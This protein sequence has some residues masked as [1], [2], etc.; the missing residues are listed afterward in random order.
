MVATELVLADGSLVRASEREHA[1]L[2][3]AC[4]GGAGGN[5]GVN[6]AFVFDAVE[7]TGQVATVFDL[8]FDAGR[9]AALM[10][11]L[12]EIL[13][14]DH[15]GDVDCRVGFSVSGTGPATIALLGQYLGPEQT[16]RRLLAP[17]L[18]LSPSR[19]L[20]EQRQFWSAQDYLMMKPERSAMASA[21]LV[22]DRWLPRQ[23]VQAVVEAVTTWRPPAGA[24]GYLTL[25]AMGGHIGGVTATE[26]AFAHRRATFVID[27]GAEW[28]PATPDQA[29]GRLRAQTRALYRRLRAELGTSAAYVN[30]PDPDL[31]D[32][33][34]AYYGANY[35]RLAQVKRHY[36]PGGVFRYGQSIG[37]SRR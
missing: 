26:T 28:R 12:Q 33:A 25:F 13:Q 7:V 32:W 1:D 8:T 35:R 29:V 15:A 5:F 27:I 30:F 19:S 37:A 6:T 21:S 4:R 16:A 22:P 34:D 31:T 18:A 20:I 36:D 17:L 10:E 3:W 23:A 14:H 9:G 2:L 24:T 11:R